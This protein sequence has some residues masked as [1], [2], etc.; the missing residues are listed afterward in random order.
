MYG[1]AND[2]LS[3]EHG[4]P[5]SM[6]HS[7]L[8]ADMLDTRFVGGRVAIMN[9]FVSILAAYGRWSGEEERLLQEYWD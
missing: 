8:V 7:A 5:R 9:M 4:V 1:L 3:N 6:V 2:G